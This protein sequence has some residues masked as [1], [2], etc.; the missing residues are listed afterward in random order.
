[1]RKLEGLFIKKR[2]EKNQ[3][4]QGNYRCN[5]NREKAMLYWVLIVPN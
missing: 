1:M 2:K 5:K 4:I 3:E